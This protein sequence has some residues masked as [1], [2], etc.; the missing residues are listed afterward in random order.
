MHGGRRLEIP[1]QF[2]V[3][4]STLTY[5]VSPGVQVTLEMAAI[6]IPATEKANHEVAGSLRVATRAV[7]IAGESQVDGRQS[8]HRL[9]PGGPLL[10]VIWNRQCAAGAKARWLTR[11]DENNWAFHQWKNHESRAPR[12]LS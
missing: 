6:D 2:V 9:R 8:T 11:A 1:S 5:E 12:N 10:I 4:A 7:R 3:T